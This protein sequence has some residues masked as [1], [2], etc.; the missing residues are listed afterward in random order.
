MSKALDEILA[1]KPEGRP[2]IYAYAIDDPAHAGLLTIGQ[3]TRDVRQRGAEQ[4]ERSHEIGALRCD[5]H[6]CRPAHR[7]AHEVDRAAALVIEQADDRVGVRVQRVP[8]C[9]RGEPEAGKVQCDAG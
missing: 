8:R 5:E 7:V 9:G 1:P 3:T 6:G 4:R 2:R